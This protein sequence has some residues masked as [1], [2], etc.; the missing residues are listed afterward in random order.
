[1]YAVIDHFK[2]RTGFPVAWL[3]LTLAAFLP[4]CTSTAERLSPT[5]TL[6][7]PASVTPI[8][9][10]STKQPTETVLTRTPTA[11]ILS[12]ITATQPWIPT[13]FTN[14]LEAFRLVYNPAATLELPPWGSISMLF[15][16]DEIPVQPVYATPEFIPYPTPQGMEHSADT[17]IGFGC[18]LDY[19]GWATC[20]PDNPLQRFGCDIFVDPRGLDPDALLVANCKKE[21]EEHEAVKINGLYLTGCAFRTE[22][23]YIFEIGG[24]YVLVSSTDELKRLF[25]PIDSTQEAVAYAQLATG[26]D[27]TYSFEYDPTLMYFH[28]TI[29]ATQAIQTGD[30][31]DVNLFDMVSCG[32]EPWFNNQITIRVDR[33]GRVTWLDAVPIFMTT[34]WSCAD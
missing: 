13:P 1:M 22:N 30:A 33:T 29:T 16:G 3:L 12:S 7:P 4:A 10:T 19:W 6:P 15:W 17:L 28:E 26:L 20:P 21:T 24:Q 14:S 8:P 31:F 27:A 18:E 9:P 2:Q 23:R 11:T 5:P 25:T 34:G 32:C